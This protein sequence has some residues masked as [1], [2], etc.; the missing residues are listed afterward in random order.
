[1]YCSSLCYEQSKIPTA[2]LDVTGSSTSP[3]CNNQCVLFTIR[4]SICNDVTMYISYSDRQCSA[5]GQQQHSLKERVFSGRSLEDRFW[6]KEPPLAFS[7]ESSTMRSCMRELRS[8]DYVS[9]QVKII[10]LCIHLLPNAF[11]NEKKKIKKKKRPW[12]L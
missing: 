12:C 11:K 2:D 1:M 8:I 6:C 4:L 5:C 10:L 3:F 9:F 7:P